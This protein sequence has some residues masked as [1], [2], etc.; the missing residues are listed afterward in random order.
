M[1][2]LQRFDTAAMSLDHTRW[3]MF[4]QD[5]FEIGISVHGRGSLFEV[6]GL[7]H[8]PLEPV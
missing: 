7:L 6:T 8:F 2:H 3:L 1:L 4:W 5:Y